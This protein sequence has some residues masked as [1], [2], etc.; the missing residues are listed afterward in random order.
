MKKKAF[1]IYTI[2]ILAFATSY[3]FYLF[4]DTEPAIDNLIT[5]NSRASNISSTDD[6]S[7]FTHES[8]VYNELTSGESK[9]QVHSKELAKENHSR[10]LSNGFQSKPELSIRDIDFPE[11][12]FLAKIPSHFAEKIDR[13][14]IKATNEKE[15]GSTFEMAAGSLNYYLKELVV[16][17]K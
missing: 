16:Q 14:S 11:T 4:F 6:T 1:N 13:Y 5:E 15:F 7:D 10:N 12:E 17:P 2:L 9:A 3:L 8:Y